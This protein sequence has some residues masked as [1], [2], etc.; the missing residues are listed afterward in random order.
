MRAQRLAGD[1]DTLLGRLF[2]HQPQVGQDLVGVL[3][4][5]ARVG[6]VPERLVGHP[7]GGDE[8]VVPESHSPTTI[9]PRPIGR[10]QKN[11]RT[12]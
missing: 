6:L 9:L 5:G 7:Q 11:S 8:A 3:D 2:Q 12:K 10:T 4:A 1:R